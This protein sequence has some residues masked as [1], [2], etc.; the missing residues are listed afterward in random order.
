[1]IEVTFQMTS[2]AETYARET[3]L[4]WPLLVDDS[5]S[6]Y[7]AYGMHRGRVWDVWGP[8][9]WWVYIKLMLHGRLLILPAGDPNQLGGDVL[10][11]PKG[12]VRLHHVGS[13]PADR[14]SV[15]GLLDIVRRGTGASG[16]TSD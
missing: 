11:D 2:L 13:G 3:Q 5:L 7:S 9:S 14:P 15:P 4:H 8:A 16:D 10:I 1:M 6:L 12:I